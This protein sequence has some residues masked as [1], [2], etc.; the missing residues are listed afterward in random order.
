LLWEAYLTE[1][2]LGADPADMRTLLTLTLA[3]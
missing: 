3:D 1:P 2:M